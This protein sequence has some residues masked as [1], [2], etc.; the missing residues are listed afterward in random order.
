M[1]PKS[2]WTIGFAAALVVGLFAVPS[3]ADGLNLIGDANFELPLVFADDF[4]GPYSNCFGFHNGVVANDN[5]SGWQLIGKG[6]ID[7]EGNPIPGAPATTM[8]VGFDYTEPDNTSGGTLHFHPQDGLQSLDLTGEGNQG[9]TNGIKRAVGTTAGLD[10]ILT[11]WVGHQY[12]L[13]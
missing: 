4:C 9:T 3:R 7:G 11:F 5:I 6:G 10:Y 1:R 2:G 13:A 12:S 8:V